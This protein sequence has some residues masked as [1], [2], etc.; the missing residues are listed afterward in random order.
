MTAV[1]EPSVCHLLDYLERNAAR[2]PARI[3]LQ[4]QTRRWTFTQ[5]HA[6]TDTVA[7]NLARLGLS[8]QRVVL[9]TPTV[10]ELPLTYYGAWKSGAVAVPLNYAFRGPELRRVLENCRP[11]ALIVHA[12]LLPELRRAGAD[13]LAAIPHLFLLGDMPVS[14]CRLRPWAELLTPCRAAFRSD[15]HAPAVIFH[16]SGTTGRPKGVVHTLA[17]ASCFAH[18]YQT[19]PGGEEQPVTVIARNCYHSGGFFNLT[20]AL[21]T[22]TTCVLTDTGT[23]RPE[24]YLADVLKYRATQIFL[25]VAMLN[26]LLQSPALAAEHF[27][28][29]AFVSVGADEVK[30]YQHDELARVTAL[31]LLVR[32]SSTEAT[33]VSINAAPDAGVR[34]TSVGVPFAHFEWKLDAG[35][36]GQE[37]LLRGPGVFQGYLNNP[38]ANATCFTADGWYRTGDLFATDGAGRLVFRGRIGNTL[39]IGGSKVDPDEIESVAQQ[40]PAVA[41]AVAV[42]IPDSVG[43]VPVLYL[44]LKSNS[45]SSAVVAAV[46]SHLQQEIAGYKVPVAIEV[47]PEFPVTQAGKVD[48]GLLSATATARSR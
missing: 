39:K 16:T 11:Q 30:P 35:A 9:F 17:S 13:L 45:N 47:L 26:K 8:G 31:P 23:F 27:A 12:T 32:Y 22:G 5:L 10:P 18:A 38:E 34:R 37:L 41:E 19:L 24:D 42:G 29:A 7:A 44:R 6:A 20:G 4:H 43:Q 1:A 25:N 33:S 36:D 14:P 40:H 28:R 46:L 48:R 21:S 15:P 3:A 2:H